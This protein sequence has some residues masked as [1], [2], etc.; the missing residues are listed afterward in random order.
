MS[1]E[2]ANE[3]SR[4]RILF[5][6]IIVPGHVTLCPSKGKRPG[7]RKAGEQD[8]R[9]A[10]GNSTKKPGREHMNEQGISCRVQAH[11]AALP[12]MG[13]IRKHMQG[14]TTQAVLTPVTICPNRSERRRGRRWASDRRLHLFDCKQRLIPNIRVFSRLIMCPPRP[15]CKPSE[16]WQSRKPVMD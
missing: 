16:R 12:E 9:Q 7:D 4:V 5:S 3:R 11:T 8:L 14:I 2:P 15:V 10:G 6:V 13:L 1:T